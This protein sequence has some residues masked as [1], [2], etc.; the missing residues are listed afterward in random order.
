MRKI[1]VTI[2]NKVKH[3]VVF[4]VGELIPSCSS[5]RILYLEKSK[6]IPKP[7]LRDKKGVRLYTKKQRDTIE[8]W[9]Y[10]YFY[11]RKKYDSWK[12]TLYNK[13][14]ETW[15]DEFKEG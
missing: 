11:N 7:I 15:N 12:D 9:Y 6:A 2:H 13:L 4:T 14:M 1:K 8:K 10:N 3:F 5:T